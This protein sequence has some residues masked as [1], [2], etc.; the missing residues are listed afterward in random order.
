MTLFCPTIVQNIGIYGTFLFDSTAIICEALMYKTIAKLLLICAHGD[1]RDLFFSS[2]TKNEC[3]TPKCLLYACKK[4]I[5]NSY[6]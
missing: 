1:L 5:Q 4:S 6:A 2:A 3:N